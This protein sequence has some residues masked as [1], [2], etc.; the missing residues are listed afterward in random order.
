MSPPKTRRLNL[1]PV[2][3]PT[4]FIRRDRNLSLSVPNFRNSS[5][6]CL[7]HTKRSIRPINRDRKSV[8]EL[9]R[10]CDEDDGDDVPDDCFLDNVPISPR[11][12][13]QQSLCHSKSTSA[14]PERPIRKKSKSFGNGT[15]AQPAEQG[16]LRSPRSSE[17]QKDSTRNLTTGDDHSKTRAMSWSAAMFDL[18]QETKRLTQALEEYERTIY[19]PGSINYVPPEKPRVQSMFSELPPLRGTEMIIESLPISKEKEAVLSRTRPSW[20]PPKDPAEEK[21]HVKEYQRMIANFLEADRKNI[22]IGRGH[23][24]FDMIKWRAVHRT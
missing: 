7:S 4:Q 13:S 20:L 19:E 22:T 3:A 1:S 5:I 8:E 9:E 2:P 16:E 11:P 18:S 23:Q 14:S 12:H 21:R 10:E 6:I 17:I 24:S 15:S